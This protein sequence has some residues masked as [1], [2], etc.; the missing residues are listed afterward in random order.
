MVR[1]DEDRARGARAS[2]RANRDLRASFPWTGREI[3]IVLTGAVLM[4]FAGGLVGAAVGMDELADPA[5]SGPRLRVSP[6]GEVTSA[7][8]SRDRPSSDTET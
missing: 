7:S 4:A 6:R 8:L 2:A 1:T 3:W 5:L